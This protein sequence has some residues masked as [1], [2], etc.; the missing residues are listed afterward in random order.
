MKKILKYLKC[1]GWII[2]INSILS[3]ILT[4]LHYFDVFSPNTIKTLKL[5]SV[6]L[7]MLIGG[8]YI[9]RKS[10]KKGY[11]EGVKIGLVFI[12]LIFLFTLISKNFAFKS[13]IYYFI[14]LISS[15]VGAMIGIQIKKD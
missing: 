9:G 8:I 3:F 7:S 6:I 13:L 4:L 11:L 10:N 5:L 14:I 15:T 2:V 1:I 12:V